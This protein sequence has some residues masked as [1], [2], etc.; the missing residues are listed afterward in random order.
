VKLAL[1]RS[2]PVARLGLSLLRG[3]GASPRTMCP[4]SCRW[5]RPKCDTIRPAIAGW[6]RETLGSIGGD[7]AVWVLEFLD[8]KHA[9]VRAIGWKWLHETP[10]KDT[11]AIWH[12]LL[13]SP[14][15]DIRDRSS[16]GWRSG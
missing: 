9:D 15:D 2:L 12:R 13:E 5:C 11:P 10:L 4:R 8:S 1:H 14:H 16:P 3:R 7:E 6:L